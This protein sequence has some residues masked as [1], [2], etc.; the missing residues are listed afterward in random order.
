MTMALRP[1]L[2]TSSSDFALHPTASSNVDEF[3]PLLMRFRRPSLLAPPR[4]TFYSEGRLHSPLAAS[5]FTVPM[6]RRHTTSSTA[7]GEESESDKE[8]MWTDSTSSN[9]SGA[10]TPSLAV[11]VASSDKHKSTS[12]L[13]S[14]SSMNSIQSHPLSSPGTVTSSKTTRRSSPSPSPRRP[15]LSREPIPATPPSKHTRRIS[16]SVGPTTSHTQL[17]VT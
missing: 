13:D 8:R 5:S 14:D 2:P 6:S 4:D 9:S 17:V 10:N 1:S 3:N 7:S 12:S 11:P 16:H 15:S